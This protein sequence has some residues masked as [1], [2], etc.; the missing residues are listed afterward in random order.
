MTDVAQTLDRVVE[1]MREP[2]RDYV[3]LLQGIAEGQA[4]ALALFGAIAAGAFDPTRHAARNVLVVEKVDLDMLRRLSS[5][6]VRLGKARIAAP[7]VMTPKY[8][9]ESL[10]TFPLELLDIQ[11]CHVT[12]FGDD[13]FV[14]LKFE[15]SHVRLQCERE[16]KS[17]L[18]G[19]R[20]GLLAAAGRDK[21]LG[22]LGVDVAEGLLRTLRGMLW[23]KGTR[24]ALSA[25]KVLEAMEK[26]T[27]RK[28]G[29]IRIALD[30]SATHGWD[31]FKTLYHDVEAL[32]KIADAW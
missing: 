30:P 20:Q 12:L 9:E 21:I 23:L 8:I 14:D 1:S 24:D 16:L 15:E 4:K 13:P 5:E 29:G 28:L 18:I 19:M 10:D 6:G 27:D 2:L 7:L 26:V 32:G 25:P 31:Q 17:I 3:T 11:Q 22:A